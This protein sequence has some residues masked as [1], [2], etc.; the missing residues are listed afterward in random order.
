MGSTVLKDISVANIALVA[1]N[2]NE[3][4]VGPVDIGS[5]Q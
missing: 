5:F 2:K 4:N 1:M 3:C